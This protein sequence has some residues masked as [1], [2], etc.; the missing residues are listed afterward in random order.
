MCKRTRRK[1]WAGLASAPY[2]PIAAYLSAISWTKVFENQRFLPT[3][4][5]ARHLPV[6]LAVCWI[7]AIALGGL[8]AVLGVTLQRNR[9]EA[10]GLIFLLTG[11]I[12]YGIG[13]SYETGTWHTIPVSVA[14]AL[15]C[16]IRLHVLSQAR[17][18]Q[19][20]AARIAKE[21]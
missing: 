12:F 15:M 9:I 11:A 20:G 18:A 1:F 13:S 21:E 5:L 2:T 3:A 8:C 10:S 17:K 4:G 19:E 14:V 7:M 16:A 6:W